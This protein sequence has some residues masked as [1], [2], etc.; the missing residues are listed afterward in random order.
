MTGYSTVAVAA[1]VS[2]A[3]GTVHADTATAPAQT[4]TVAVTNE[5]VDKGRSSTFRY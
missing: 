5:S 2:V 3:S 1:G 4:P